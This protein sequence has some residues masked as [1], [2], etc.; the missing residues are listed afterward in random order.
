[1]TNA[2]FVGV[3]GSDRSLLA[4]EWA[5]RNAVFGAGNLQLVH[6]YGLSG[7][8]GAAS[9][10][11][12]GGDVADSVAAA[13]EVVERAAILAMA[14]NSHA[15]VGAEVVA[16]SA[17]STLR[18]LTALRPVDAM[19]VGNRGRTR[20]PAFLG[21]VSGQLVAD[22]GCPTVV[23]GHECDPG[24]P[25]V[26][27]VDHS[28][29][30]RVAVDT[31]FQYAGAV[32]AGVIGV[33]SQCD[34]RAGAMGIGGIAS[35]RDTLVSTEL[36]HRAHLV[37]ADVLSGP[38]SRY[39]SVTVE[40]FVAE[41]GPA[42]AILAAAKHARLIVVGKNGHSAPEQDRVGSTCLTVLSN[43]SCPVMVVRQPAAT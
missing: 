8:G 27:G 9:S 28:P 21:S 15:R 38:A 16:G 20:G 17:G 18:D 36:N 33:H 39:P 10:S 3:D 34:M 43:A 37:L 40:S 32:G 41:Q 25:V 35:R 19:V 6:A 5:A 24:G 2:L 30:G 22:A 7:H 26:V 11:V 29:A 14:I 23:V 4:V 12:R 31:A 13:E 42:L 1:M